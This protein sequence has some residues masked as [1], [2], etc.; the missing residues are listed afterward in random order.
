MSCVGV[1]LEADD[2]RVREWA[3]YA[4]NLTE[5][6]LTYHN[7]IENPTRDWLRVEFGLMFA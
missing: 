6:L 4:L 2:H 5:M 7:R 1:I 3:R